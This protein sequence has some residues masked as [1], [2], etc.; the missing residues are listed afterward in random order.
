MFI[1]IDLTRSDIGL[2][3]WQQLS[4]QRDNIKKKIKT[5]SRVPDGGTQL[6]EGVRRWWPWD[7]WELLANASIPSISKNA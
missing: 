4:L 7:C 5:L 3:F 6:Q 2:D 1:H